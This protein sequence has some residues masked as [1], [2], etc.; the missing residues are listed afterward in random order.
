MRFAL[1]LA[2]IFFP[3]LGAANAPADVPSCRGQSVEQ[4]I[5]VF[6]NAIRL[7]EKFKRLANE[8]NSI[9]AVYTETRLRNSAFAETR[10]IPCA[11][12]A[13]RLLMRA[14][15]RALLNKVLSLGVS[16]ENLADESLSVVLATTFVAQ[17]EEFERDLKS[18]NAASKLIL[19]RRAQDGL[20]S[21][22]AEIVKRIIDQ[23]YK[24]LDE[25]RVKP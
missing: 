23:R 20:R 18:R 17:P 8:G 16:Y 15:H 12:Q 2:A 25:L 6:D 14:N 24:R 4:L 10:V 1:A 22:R 7:N 11:E 9:D 21:D 13:V 5:L 19:V 3:I